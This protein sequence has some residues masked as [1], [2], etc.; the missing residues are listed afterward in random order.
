[1]SGGLD[2]CDGPP[3]ATMGPPGYLAPHMPHVVGQVDVLA[4]HLLV[5]VS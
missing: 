4:D 2:A 1:M 3:S 5:W